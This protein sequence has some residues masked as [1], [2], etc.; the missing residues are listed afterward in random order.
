VVLAGPRSHRSLVPLRGLDDG[1]AMNHSASSNMRQ[2]VLKAGLTGVENL[3]Q[4]T[5][6]VPEPG[7]GQVRVQMAA[8]SLNFRDQ[9]WVAG[10]YGPVPDS[11]TVVLSDG[12]GVIDEVGE[13]VTTVSVGDRVTS[14][15]CPDWTDGPL[16]GGLGLGPGSTGDPGMLA[17]YVVLPAEATTSAPASLSLTEA[18]GLPCAGLTAWTALNGDRPYTRPIAA[19]EKVLV[20]GSG[21]V[22]LIALGLAIGAGA[23]VWATSG[24][25]DKAE[26]VKAMGAVDAVN[27]VQRPDWGAAVFELTGGG[28]DRVVNAAG[29]EAIDQSIAALRNG[30]EIA[31]MGF[32]DQAAGSPDFIAL[33]TKTAAIRGTRVGSAAAH[34]DMVRAIDQSTVSVPIHRTFTFDQTPDAFRAAV[35]PD[36]YGKVVIQLD[37]A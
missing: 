6:P 23:Q 12:A 7:P 9:L 14:L 18:A 16:P 21:G 8:V 36:V 26:R 35:A 4:Q 28:V 17:E 22:S 29:S 5:V 31:L 2:W 34:A 33:M 27:R 15:Y 13:G 11:D 30:G 3:E 10:Q 32:K 25:N 20:L 1:G 24:S 37:G 19:G